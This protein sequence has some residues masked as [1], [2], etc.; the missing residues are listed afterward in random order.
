MTDTTSITTLSIVTIVGARPQF[1]KAAALSRAFARWNQECNTCEQV[2]FSEAILHT[3]QHYDDIMSK[4]FF[5]QM[6]IPE[7]SANLSIGGGS[8]G[9]MTG[10]MLEAIE[11]ELLARNPDCVLVY[12]DT[13]STLAGALAA[14]KLH[15]PVAHVEAGLRSF[16]RRM[17]EEINRIATDHISSLLFCPTTVAAEHLNTEGI[18]EGVHLVGDVMYDAAM[19]YRPQAI[20]PV[21]DGAFALATIHRADNTD[22]PERL[23]AIL[24]AMGNA[25]CP[26]RLACH[27]RTA[28]AIQSHNIPI[29]GTLEL[30]E[31]LSYFEM[32]GA[33]DACE[34]VVTDSGGL[35]KE[36]YFFKKK[37]LT[38]RP[39]TEWT[40]LLDAGVN[41]LVEPETLGEQF[42]W[43]M[44]TPQQWPPTLYGSADAAGHIVKL[45]ANSLHPPGRLE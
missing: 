34:F 33:L 28:K 23:Q 1:V 32:L 21:M 20:A 24:D 40:E 35:Q 16:N 30:I 6:Q 42:A 7:A 14:V 43:A 38:V 39:Q 2:R 15:I 8:H 29:K 27:P 25:P 9:Q 22:N 11:T 12:G 10:R 18:R 4:V 44:I 31:P 13:N 37:C 3:G 17:P 19:F 41:R 26:V 5:E 45:L 36:A